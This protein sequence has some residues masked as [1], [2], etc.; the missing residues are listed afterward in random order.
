[1]QENHWYDAT[2]EDFINKQVIAYVERYKYM[3]T[4]QGCDCEIVIIESTMIGLLSI[5]PHHPSTSKW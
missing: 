3:I 2:F 4:N 1:M 5:Q